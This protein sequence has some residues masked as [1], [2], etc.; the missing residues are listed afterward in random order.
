LSLGWVA[1]HN[2]DTGQHDDKQKFHFCLF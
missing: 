1:I 2:Q